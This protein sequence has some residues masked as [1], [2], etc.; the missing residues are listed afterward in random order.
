MS[1]LSLRFESSSP[2]ISDGKSSDR[3][4]AVNI[5]I[6]M[7][8]ID[9]NN[10]ANKIVPNRVTYFKPTILVPNSKAKRI[11]LKNLISKPNPTISNPVAYM[12]ISTAPRIYIATA[13]VRPK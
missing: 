1:K 12:K 11:K 7:H 13:D 9:R 6:Y 3:D 2:V 5:P 4:S 8:K 10:K